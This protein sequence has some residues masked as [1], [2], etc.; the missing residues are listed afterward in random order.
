MATDQLIARDAVIRQAAFDH[1]RACR[2][3]ILSHEDIA[4]GFTFQ[5]RRW[6]IWNPQRGI[7]KPLGMP[8]LLSIRTVF[9]RKGR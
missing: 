7:F 8:F 3:L 1:V 2:D 6:P 4:R 9:P 5:G